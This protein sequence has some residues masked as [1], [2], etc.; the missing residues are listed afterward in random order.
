MRCSGCRKIGW[1]FWAT[2][3]FVQLQPWLPGGNPEAWIEILHR[4]ETLDIATAVPGHGA[5]GTLANSAS[6]RGYI[7]TLLNLTRE[8]AAS[9]QAW[10]DFKQQT[11]AHDLC[12][13]G[14]SQLP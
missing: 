13:L 1:R 2:C 12:V 5:V 3:F 14:E 4:V 7:E 6:L 10:D 8:A 9:G 11:D